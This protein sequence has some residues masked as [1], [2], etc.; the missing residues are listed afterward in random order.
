MKR[1]SNAI[2][3]FWCC[4]YLLRPV[5]NKMVR[6]HRQKNLVGLFC[7]RSSHKNIWLHISW[8]HTSQE[9]LTS[10]WHAL[11]ELYW[12]PW[13]PSRPLNMAAESPFFACFCCCCGQNEFLGTKRISDPYIRPYPTTR[14]LQMRQFDELTIRFWNSGH[15]FAHASG[16]CENECN[17]GRYAPA[18]LH[19][20]ETSNNML[21]HTKSPVKFDHS[22]LS[23][24]MRTFCVILTKNAIFRQV[25]FRH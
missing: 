6:G 1:S 24:R 7:T 19:P 15:F 22:Y 4:S 13:H 11:I 23:L 18:N 12:P 16:R 25:A 21:K 5:R 17:A 14:T 20:I 2:K 10:L 8:T 9:P 3:E